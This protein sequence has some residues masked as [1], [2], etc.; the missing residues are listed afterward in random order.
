L[1]RLGLGQFSNPN[2]FEENNKTKPSVF[3]GDFKKKIENKFDQIKNEQ[4]IDQDK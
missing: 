2:W 4:P 1:E 3:I